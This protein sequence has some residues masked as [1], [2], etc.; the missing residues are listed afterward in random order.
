MALRSIDSPIDGH[1]NPTLGF[2]FFDAATGSLGQGLSVAAG[3][4]GGSSDAAATLDGALE[5]WGA[6]EAL[7]V[8]LRAIASS[9]GHSPRR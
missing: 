4:A 8:C 1:P 5:A 2:P 7:S 9:C 6:S 3:L